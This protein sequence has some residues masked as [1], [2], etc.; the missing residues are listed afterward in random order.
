MPPP[1]EALDVI[2][3]VLDLDFSVWLNSYEGINGQLRNRLD[4][5]YI[6][7]IILMI[8]LYHHECQVTR[9]FLRHVDINHPTCSYMVK[10]PYMAGMVIIAD[11]LRKEATGYENTGEGSTWKSRRSLG[12]RGSTQYLPVQQIALHNN[13]MYYAFPIN[14]GLLNFDLTQVVSGGQAKVQ[15]SFD[16]IVA[17]AERMKPYNGAYFQRVVGSLGRY[18]EANLSNFVV[19]ENIVSY[20]WTNIFFQSYPAGKT[21]RCPKVNIKIERLAPGRK[22]DMSVTITGTKDTI[23]D[24][25][26]LP[27]PSNWSPSCTGRLRV[28]LATQYETDVMI[29]GTTYALS[30]RFYNGV[31]HTS[32][33]SLVGSFAS[34]IAAFGP[35]LFHT[36]G[37]ALSNLMI[38][39]GSNFENLIQSPQFIELI[40]SVFE[41][42]PQLYAA[43]FDPRTGASFQD[44][45]LRLTELIT[46][47]QLAYEF[48]TAP[49]LRAIS[50]LLNQSL[51]FRKGEGSFT[52]E[53]EGDFTSQPLSFQ[54]AV[55][56]S[57]PSFYGL[58]SIGVMRYKVIFRTTV[59]SSME[60][61]MAAKAILTNDPLAM[62]H[63]YPTPEGIW[64]VQPMSFVVDW[65]FQV[66]PM[67]SDATSYWRS[68]TM[69]LRIGHTVHV[70][71]RYNDGRI[72]NNFWRSEESKLPL[73]PPGESWLPLGVLPQI[74]I[75]FGIQN[76][77]R[78]GGSA[79][80]ALR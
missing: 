63:G 44:R 18:G 15:L 55:M 7:P 65:G 50:N 34:N 23:I 68:L 61:S 10:S 62:V 76:L 52:I 32:L 70:K 46:G 45:V 38:D 13:G 28:N 4:L 60:A 5:L 24:G 59:Y 66:G 57:S 75:P 54:K 19:G 58:S 43:V 40:S 9:Y 36:Q 78:F 49:T 11:Y 27:P 21:L 31:Y 48:A 25:S 17:F 77:F 14:F 73:D 47:G 64:A 74:A 33:G 56:Q 29:G 35:G 2:T 69:P 30:R 51:D 80:Q 22:G 42:A 39:Y 20:T 79:I 41:N 3:E 37:R 12:L 1:S 26:D 71:F 67:I 53:G 8:H 72:F 6:D 16:D